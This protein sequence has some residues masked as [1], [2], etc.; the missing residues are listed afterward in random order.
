MACNCE[1][2][3]QIDELYKAYSDKSQ[4]PDKPK[5]FDYFKYYAGNIT[6]YTLALIAFPFLIIYV[7]LL[8]FWREESKIHINDIDLIKKFGILK[9]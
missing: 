7:L 1:T 3:K 4:L 5:A 8:L 6:A 2:Q 9:N